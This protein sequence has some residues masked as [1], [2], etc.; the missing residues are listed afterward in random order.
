MELK[1]GEVLCDIKDMMS[2][3]DKLGWYTCLSYYRDSKEEFAEFVIDDEDF[4]YFVRELRL[5]SKTHDLSDI[6]I[7]A[8]LNARCSVLDFR[9]KKVKVV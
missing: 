6:E 2:Q 7:T 9:A 5:Y 3:K 4:E 1:L 8:D